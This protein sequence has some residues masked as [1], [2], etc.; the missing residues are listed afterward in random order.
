[1]LE[2]QDWQGRAGQADRPNTTTLVPVQTRW[3]QQ[4]PTAS[5]H[6]GF[7]RAAPLAAAPAE[8]RGT[9][10]C[11][12]GRTAPLTAA[13]SSPTAGAVLLPALQSARGGETQT[14]LERGRRKGVATTGY[15]AREE[16][17]NSMSCIC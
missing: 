3:H 6:C 7:P 5:Q 11:S 12:G 15:N 16:Q 17:K 9:A 2:S 10:Q 1:M 8:H 13:F 4:P 14:L